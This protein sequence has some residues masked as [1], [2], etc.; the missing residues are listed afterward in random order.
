MGQ[1]LLKMAT[2][3]KRS[4]PVFQGEGRHL[5]FV[6][7]AAAGSIEIQGAFR[8]HPEMSLPDIG[9]FIDLPMNIDGEIDR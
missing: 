4:A 6:V 1:G 2:A 8:V 7:E 5:G 3:R 9:T